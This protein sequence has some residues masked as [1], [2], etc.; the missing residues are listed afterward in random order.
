MGQYAHVKYA[1]VAVHKLSLEPR[2]IALRH[3]T[4]ELKLAETGLNRLVYGLMIRSK[5][6]LDRASI[7]TLVTVMM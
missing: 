3:P 7:V 5:I 6:R 2:S 4:A 1:A